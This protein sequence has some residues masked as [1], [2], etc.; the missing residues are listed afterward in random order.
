MVVVV[1][2]IVNIIIIAYCIHVPLVCAQCWYPELG[3]SFYS[4]K[5]IVYKVSSHMFV[6]E[7]LKKGD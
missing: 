5:I 3:G 4:P 2:W 7:S 1:Q 6:L